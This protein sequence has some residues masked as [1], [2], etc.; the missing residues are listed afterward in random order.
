MEGIVALSFACNILQL[1]QLGSQPVSICKQFYEDESPI[2]RVDDHCRGLRAVSSKLKASFSSSGMRT[3][4]TSSDSELLSLAN[5][6]VK[7]ADDLDAE[8]AKLRPEPGDRPT[9]KLMKGMK[10]QFVGKKRIG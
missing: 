1:I 5:K 3:G 7:L 8:L 6:V 4:S 9:K 10:Y 2:E